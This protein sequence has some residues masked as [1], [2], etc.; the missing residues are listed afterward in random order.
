MKVYKVNTK[1]YTD[2]FFNLEPIGYY[3]NRISAASGC[4][5][6]NPSASNIVLTISASSSAESFM[7]S[8]FFRKLSLN[9]CTILL[10]PVN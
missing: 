4:S 1:R 6:Q 9:S 2:E 7:L 3:P 10:L 5:K 8:Y